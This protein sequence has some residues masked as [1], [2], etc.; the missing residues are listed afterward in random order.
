MDLL[1]TH[2]YFLN[3]DPAERRIMKPYPPLGLLYLSAYLK[4]RGY[5]VE[6]LDTTFRTP[7]DVVA[8]LRRRR[9]ATVG[10]YANLM[11]KPNVL[12]LIRA[13]QEWDA[14]VILG[15]PEPPHYAREYLEWG[16]DI[17]VVGEGEHT[18]EA[19]LAHLPDHGLDG[20][21]AIPGLIFSGR[22][23]TPV[24]T[25]PR[26]F[27]HPLDALPFP[28]RGAI[29]LRGYLDTWRTY[30]GRSS[31]SLIS[32]RGCPYTCTWCSHAVFGFSHRR[33]SPENVAD[34]VEQIA[35]EYRPDQ[36]WYADDVFT[37]HRGWFFAYAAELDRRNLRIPFECISR[38]DRLDE[39]VIEK[40]ADM[41]CFRLWIGSES[42]SQRLLEAM[43]RRT[44]AE[45][46]RHLTR[47][48]QRHGIQA[49]M[50]LMFGYEG[51]TEADL[52]ATVEHVKRANPDVFL[53]TVAYPI[54]GTAYYEQ[55]AD[56]VTSALPW[57]KRTDR[58]LTV[59][60]RP[61]KRYYWFANR[62]LVNEVAWHRCRQNGGSRWRR[63]KAYLNARLGRMGMA[64][65]RR[66][67]EPM[68]QPVGSDT[69]GPRR[70]PAQP[71]VEV[72]TLKKPVNPET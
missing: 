32:A 28:D 33:R 1:L 49:G 69:S 53:T 27:I 37:I 18:L 9:P 16:A 40:L 61:T 47:R 35:A 67:R 7:A 54:K 43:Q 23:G 19:L 45:R 42:G 34:E 46:V 41:G 22:D 5:R 17:I 29:D 64:L 6:V 63:C 50:F 38:E 48:L 12:E 71:D 39:A 62:W 25:P 24:R 10:L 51:E 72:G 30:H 57:E 70:L 4:A 31:A 14:T 68:R 59:A 21:E 60:G 2:G 55:V 3:E 66:R 65:T 56:R 26:P 11:T 36:L 44:D 15:G 58:D 52:Q 13:C 20:L 8:E